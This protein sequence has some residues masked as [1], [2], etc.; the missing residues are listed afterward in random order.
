VSAREVHAYMTPLLGDRSIS[1]E[2]M[3]HSLASGDDV[4]QAMRA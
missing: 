2:R 3:S 1:R 4:K